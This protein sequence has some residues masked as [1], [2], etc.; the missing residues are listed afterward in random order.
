MWL[1]SHDPEWLIFKRPLTYDLIFFFLGLYALDFSCFL[2]FTIYYL[3]KLQ[4]N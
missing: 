2:C 4:I 3:S 1:N